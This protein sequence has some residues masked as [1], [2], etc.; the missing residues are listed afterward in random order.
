MLTEERASLALGHSA[1]DTEL[2]PIVECVGPALELYRAVPANCRGLPLSCS[3][4][5]QIVRVTSTTTSLGD[6]SQSSF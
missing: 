2:D 1:P 3:A 6:P 5:E 4:D